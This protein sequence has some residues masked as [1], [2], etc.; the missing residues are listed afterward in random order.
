MLPA[1][2]EPTNGG[3]GKEVGGRGPANCGELDVCAGVKGAGGTMMVVD[4]GVP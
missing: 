1:E 2:G 3:G 4:D